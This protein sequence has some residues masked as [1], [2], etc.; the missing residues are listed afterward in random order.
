MTAGLVR[1]GWGSVL[2]VADGFVRIHVLGMKETPDPRRRVQDRIPVAVR[3][4]VACSN[5]YHSRWKAVG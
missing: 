4:I 5:M 2:F 1:H 3:M